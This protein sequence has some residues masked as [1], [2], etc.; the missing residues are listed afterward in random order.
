MAPVADR[1]VSQD[2]RSSPRVGDGADTDPI[3][4]SAHRFRRAASLRAKVLGTPTAVQVGTWT[5]G[6][7]HRSRRTRGV[8]SA[9]IT[10]VPAVGPPV[11]D[12]TPDQVVSDSHPAFDVHATDPE[13]DP[14]A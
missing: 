8:D 6:S 9:T 13:G 1:G 10:V 11:F 2:T 5:I 14:I 12:Q 3:Q 4:Y 7:A